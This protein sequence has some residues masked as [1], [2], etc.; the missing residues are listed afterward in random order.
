MATERKNDGLTAAQTRAVLAM[1][2]TGDLQAACEAAGCA[3][4]TLDRWRSRPEFKEALRDARRRLIGEAV[5]MLAGNVTAAVRVLV[6][7]ATD[8]GRPAYVRVQAATAIVTKA[9]DLAQTD[10]LAERLESVEAALAE[11][12]DEGDDDE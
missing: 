6:E 9:H 4:R 7:I 12:D 5:A 8:S 1:V 3:R 2:E 11:A 10:D